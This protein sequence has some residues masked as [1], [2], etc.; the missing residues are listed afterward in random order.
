MKPVGLFLKIGRY[1]S[2][3]LFVK[4]TELHIF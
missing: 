4:V 3:T 2:F 1:V